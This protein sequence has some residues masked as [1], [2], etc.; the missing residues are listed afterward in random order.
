MMIDTKKFEELCREHTEAEAEYK[1]LYQ[2]GRI[3]NDN[4][5]RCV[6]ERNFY[7]VA[8]WQK[9]MDKLLNEL[10]TVRAKY[11]TLREELNKEKRKEA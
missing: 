1:V 9:Y 3:V 10:P 11:D 5:Q 7:Q 8:V 2:L 4:A 6:E